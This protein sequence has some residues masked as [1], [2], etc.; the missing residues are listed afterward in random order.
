MAQALEYCLQGTKPGKE[1]HYENP[2]LLCNAGRDH[3]Y[4]NTS[5]QL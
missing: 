4:A 3:R 2:N 1:I 5:H